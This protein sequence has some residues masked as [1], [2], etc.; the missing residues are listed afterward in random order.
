MEGTHESE[1]TEPT[2]S[3]T[4]SDEPVYLD[5]IPPGALGLSIPFTEEPVALS[6]TA[7]TS[8][9][10]PRAPAAEPGLP[11]RV[12]PSVTLLSLG[13]CLAG[14]LEIAVQLYILKFVGFGPTLFGFPSR[15]LLVFGLTLVA[16]PLVV[17]IFRRPVIL[18]V[19]PP[20]ALV[21]LLYPLFVPYGIPYG[22]DPIYNYQFA[23]SLLKTGHW[24]VG[25][26]AV[27][28][29]AV[30]YAYYPG[31][32][33]FNAELSAFTGVPLSR[34]I[35]WG[36]PLLRLLMLPATIYG[37]AHRYFGTRVVFGAVLIFLATPSILF[38]NPVQSEF[39]IPFF[40]LGL[41]LLGYL[42]VDVGYG[43]NRLVVAIAILT[44]I[45]VISHT[46]TA[47]T[48]DIWIG[49]C[50]LFWGL[51]R[52]Y[53]SPQTK[54]VVAV[55]G[56]YLLFLFVFTYEI[57]LPDLL[58]NYTVLA[59]T[60]NT[61]VNPSSLSLS[62]AASIGSSFP[63]YQLLWTYVVF[64][65][66]VFG[67][68]L[69]LARMV[70]TSRRR[71][72]TPNLSM[73]IITVVVTI[74]L[75]VTE[76]TFLAERNMEFGEIFMAPAAVWLVIQ[77]L[78]VGSG[79]RSEPVS[80]ARP[81]RAP[82]ARRR[83]A[84]TAAVIAL[85]VV[86]F[87]GGSLVPYSTRDQLASSSELITESPLHIEPY[88][89]SLAEWAHLHLTA[90]SWVWGDYLTYSVFGG[91]GQFN[92]QFNQYMIFNGTTIPLFVWSFVTVGTYIVVDKYM[93]TT[94][95]QF[96]GDL[97]PTGPLSPGQVEKF[98]NPA[99]FDLVYQDS[100]FTIY[101]VIGIP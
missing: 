82:S 11:Y 49:G 91:F 100:T 94:T 57:S 92:M 24:V 14:F 61:V 95:P 80:P 83:Y 87:A 64:L 70:R 26:G 29:Q 9:A 15:L 74:P 48:V 13:L 63:E 30:A 89:Y 7:P 88:A 67:S 22:Q 12:Q 101:Q 76:L 2:A 85:V 58:A 18:F 35:L 54:R 20:I 27:T 8:E 68:F 6:P 44:G 99:F 60:L 1:E 71:F 98:N 33:V 16:A 45:V 52:R 3:A 55:L 73:A 66:L 56:I 93:T 37:L 50:L 96:P 10:G 39:A 36:I 34:T 17:G 19:I 5:T 4:D 90:S 43:Q 69:A 62:G 72:V 86:I 47:Y 42:V 23:L 53:S 41:A 79:S 28:N 78:G 21:F 75:L 65:T 31:S 77:W 51:L 38:N 59:G 32:G 81:R 46:L 97:E 84:A 25:G 40:A